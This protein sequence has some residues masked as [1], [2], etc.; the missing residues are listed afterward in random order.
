MIRER[1]SLGWLALL[2]VSAGVWCGLPSAPADAN[3]E[4]PFKPV[5]SMDALMEG[6]EY[7]FGG[8]R[9]AIQGGKWDEGVRQAWILAELGNVNVHF[10]KEPKYGQLARKMSGA[11]VEL[12]R[13]MKKHDE[14]AAKAALTKVGASCKDCHDQYRK[15][16]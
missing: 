15:K 10:A 13:T 12:A 3:S 6:Q 5:Q 14:T 8:V 16:K 7:L 4:K 9:K 11:S 2:G 1:V